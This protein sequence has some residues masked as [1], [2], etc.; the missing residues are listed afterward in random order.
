MTYEVSAVERVKRP[1]RPVISPRLYDT[2]WNIS[3]TYWSF[4]PQVMNILAGIAAIP[5]TKKLGEDKWLEFRCSRS[6]A[7][8]TQ[9]LTIALSP[10]RPLQLYY[11]SCLCHVA[12]LT[13]LE[14]A[15]YSC[16]HYAR[17]SFRSHQWMIN[18]NII[19]LFFC[20]L[21]DR[22]CMGY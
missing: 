21:T 13:Q 19:R 7:S 2:K 11:I 4:P 14:A 15:S 18:G 9:L 6:V 17:I 20:S 1:W 12:G 5:E 8:I 16:K 22:L 3:L 10:I